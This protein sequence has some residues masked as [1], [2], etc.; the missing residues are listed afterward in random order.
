MSIPRASS[1]A[2]TSWTL[3]P[4]GSSE[5]IFDDRIRV[6]QVR[7]MIRI[8]LPCRHGQRAV[9]RVAAAVRSNGVALQLVRE[10]RDDRPALPRI[11]MA[12]LDGRTFLV[13]EMRMRGQH[14][15]RLA[16]RM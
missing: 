13:D 4:H 5:T 6:R 12:P 1:A 2:K 15:V 10:R 16:R 11:R 8:H 9:D 7:P 14:D 3:C